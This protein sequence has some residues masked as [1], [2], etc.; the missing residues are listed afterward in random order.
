M[1]KRSKPGKKKPNRLAAIVLLLAGLTVVFFA[2]PR[3]QPAP[4]ANLAPDVR[5]VTANGDFWLSDK[6]GETLVLYF[7]FVG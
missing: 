6:R 1:M 4:V 7:S 2:F 3:N 5:L